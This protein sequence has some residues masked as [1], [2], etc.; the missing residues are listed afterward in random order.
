MYS[1]L[2]KRREK[3]EI[4]TCTFIERLLSLDVTSWGPIFVKVCVCVCVCIMFDFC[5]FVCVYVCV[6]QDDGWLMGM[7]EGDW[8]QS[9]DNAAKGVGGGSKHTHAARFPFSAH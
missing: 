9:R 8:R 6:F 2:I 4:C 7:K 1:K 3:L 5:V